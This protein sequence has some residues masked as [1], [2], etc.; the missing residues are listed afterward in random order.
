MGQIS[1]GRNWGFRPA[2]RVGPG[3]TGKG[4]ACPHLCVPSGCDTL[5]GGHCDQERCLVHL[6]LQLLMR[7]S[8][9]VAALLEGAWRPG[10]AAGCLGARPVSCF[11][12]AAEREAAGAVGTPR[13][14]LR[15]WFHF[16]GAAD[17]LDLTGWRLAQVGVGGPGSTTQSGEH[18][19][20]HCRI[21]QPALP[22]PRGRAGVAQSGDRPAKAGER[23]GMPDRRGHQLWLL[24]APSQKPLSQALG[25]SESHLPADPEARAADRPECQ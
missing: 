2:M 5:R 21:P 19:A 15:S 18:R 6:R 20:L 24:N 17:A 22:S 25:N 9:E 4:R 1:H 8:W 12:E 3:D 13:Q 23:V 16:V 11:R 7:C 10:A 14:N